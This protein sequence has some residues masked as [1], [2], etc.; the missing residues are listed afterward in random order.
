MGELRRLALRLR[1]LVAP[2]RA[3]RELDREL[4]SHLALLEEEYLGQSLPPEQA[5]RRARVDLGGM[6]RT[7]E[8]HR[9]ARSVR[10]LEETR[11]DLAYGLR[12]LRRSPVV[13]ASAVLSLAI[14]IG[15][16]T[17]VF[18]VAEGLLFRPL[19]GVA[20]AGDLVDIDIGRADGG[21]NLLSFA[22]YAAVRDDARSFDGVYARDLFTEEVAVARPGGEPAHNARAEF[23]SLNYFDVLGVRPELGR[24]FSAAADQ[25]RGV[26]VLVVS[27]RFWTTRLTGDPDVIGRSIS[28]NGRPFVVLGVA[29]RGFRGTSMA[30]P[31]LWR[32][33]GRQPEVTGR[34]DAVFRDWASGSLIAGARLQRGVTV[35]A[36]S[37]ELAILNDRLAID[38]PS[39]RQRHFRVVPSG[40]LPANR[41]GT[42][43]FVALLAGM[44]LTVLLVTCANVS[45]VLTARGLSRGREMAVR[46]S[47]GAHRARLVRQLLTETLVLYVIGGAGGGVVA[48]GIVGLTGRW[49]ASSGLAH[50]DALALDGRVAAFS[51]SMTL[52]SAG[53]GRACPRPPGIVSPADRVPER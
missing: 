15:A 25:T 41:H 52:L 48:L 53:T 47:L 29:P 50:T 42:V 26:P 27:H 3:D 4:R 36:A 32:P 30:V 37:A 2:G 39:D 16:C 10:W 7:T 33:L 31:D 9:E 11:R 23:V 14:G 1:N 17:A 6:D 35:E 34:T 8:L 12:M 22:A 13:S 46:L 18:S 28:L 21:V 19:P 51:V 38:H 45:G 43:T 40:A 20:G 5:A 24:L 44:V 49:M